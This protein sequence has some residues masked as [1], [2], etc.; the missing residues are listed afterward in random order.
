MNSA[1]YSNI[2]S[3]EKNEDCAVILQVENA[4]LFAVA[5]G[6]GGHRGGEIA[7]EVAMGA[8]EREFALRQDF[9]PQGLFSLFQAAQSAVL[10]AAE[11]N[12][13]KMHTT[14][15]ALTINDSCAVWGHMGDS[16]LYYIRDGKIVA[17]TPDHSVAY[18][19][20]LNG[21]IR[22]ED[23]RFSPDQSRLTRSLGSAEQFKPDISQQIQL[24]PGDS[25]LLCTDGFWE[26]MAE[27]DML[28]TRQKAKNASQWLTDMVSIVKGKMKQTGEYDNYT[29]VTVVI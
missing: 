19:S 6:L 13:M 16:R 21:E 14:V 9:S 7:S 1:K 2:G 17:V 8:M 22:R 26:L 27:K 15:C 24:T 5:D 23:I 18:I 25:F 10:E 11:L 4:G 3:R 12:N 20:Y 29:I 28:I